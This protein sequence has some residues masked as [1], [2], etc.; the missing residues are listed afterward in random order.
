VVREYCHLTWISNPS[1]YFAPALPLL[2][3]APKYVIGDLSLGA[4]IQL[5]TAL[6]VVLGALKWFTDN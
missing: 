1:S 3:I 6:T 2:L 5:A 4:V